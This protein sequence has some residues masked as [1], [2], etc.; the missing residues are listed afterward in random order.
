MDIMPKLALPAT[1]P[2]DRAHAF[3][4]ELFRLIPMAEQM[5]R[6]EEHMQ[7]MFTTALSV[8][9]KD[10][11]DLEMLRIQL[12]HLGARHRNFGILPLHIKVG[13]QAFLNAVDQAAP[14]I[15]EHDRAFFESAF[16]QMAD[17]MMSQH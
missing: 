9:L 16:D 3:Y 7:R 2:R 10:A 5:F 11:G 4:D 12:R 8:M 1:F 17:A 6:S 13:R 15:S 14:S